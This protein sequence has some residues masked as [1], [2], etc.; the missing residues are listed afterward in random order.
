MHT[1]QHYDDTMS[2]IFFRE[3]E[4]P[5]PDRNLGVGSGSHATQTGRIMIELEPVII[6]ER[7]EWVLVYGDTNSTLAGS[8]V[9]AKLHVP[10]A[11]VEAGLRSFDRSMPE[12][13]NRLLTDH[14][15]SLSFCPTETAVTN[16]AREGVTAGVEL[17]GDVM[18]DL[19]LEHITEGRRRRPAIL[20]DTALEK[21]YVLATI[22]RAENTDNPERLAAILDGLAES[23]LLIVFPAHPRTRAALMAADLRIPPTLQLCEPVGYLD[24]ISLEQAAR[25]I[26]TDSGGVQ[27][28]AYFVGT[29]CVTVRETTEWPETVQAGWNV[30][31]GVNRAAI[32]RAVRE[33]RPSSERP[34]LFGDGH[35][36]DRIVRVLADAA[37][38]PV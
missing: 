20:S 7:P 35:A 23:G 11:H 17:V 33:F 2:D 37:P 5:I 12:E 24:M 3:L 19:F 1:G 16:L 30:V 14:L 31:V 18:Y 32:A 21:G 27:K 10:L 13:V 29:P 6:A 34:P 36:A 22:H 26:V 4:L 9:A 28:E 15:S 25:I 8:L 38:R